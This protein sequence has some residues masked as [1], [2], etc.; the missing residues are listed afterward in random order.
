LIPQE[1]SAELI[2]PLEELCAAVVAATGA[3]ASGIAAAA[4]VPDGHRIDFEDAL[5]AVGLLIGA[6]H[7]ADA[8]ER[9]VTAT[10]LSGTFELKIALSVIELARALERST[11]RLA[12]FGHALREHVLADLAT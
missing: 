2:D 5:A 11:D 10:I 12:G 1:L 9:K 3:A 4:E 8:A 6:E 7:E